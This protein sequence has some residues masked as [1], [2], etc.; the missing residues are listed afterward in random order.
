MNPTVNTS[1]KP[2]IDTQRLIGK[3]HKHT[4]KDHQIMKE[5]TKR[6]NEQRKITKTIGNQVII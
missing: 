2:F 4:T 3:E 1:Q 6:R 5:E